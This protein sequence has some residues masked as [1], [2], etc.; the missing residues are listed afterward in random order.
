[1]AVHEIYNQYIDIPDG[2]ATY[3]VL[4]VP[5]YEWFNKAGIK[6]AYGLFSRFKKFGDIIGERH[7]ACWFYYAFSSHGPLVDTEIVAAISSHISSP[8]ELA[9]FIDRYCTREGCHISEGSYD[10][11][12]ARLICSAL[13]FEYTKGP[14]IAFFL[15]RP[16]LPYYETEKET[17][18]SPTRVHVVSG[19]NL[20]KPEMVLKFGGLTIERSLHLMD[21]LE[22][23]LLTATPKLTRLQWKQQWLRIENWCAQHGDRV[24]EVLR[25]I[26]VKAVAEAVQKS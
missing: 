20:S 22:R 10:V 18:V 8:Q 25:D 1:M 23:H 14:Y 7:L 16:R 9:A 24:V 6:D 15:K 12:R 21:E 17:S 11:K 4:L 2:Y 3:S 26:V 13:S 5:D 19:S